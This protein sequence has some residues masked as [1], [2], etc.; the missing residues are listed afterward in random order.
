[1]RW[2]LLVQHMLAELL[3]SQPVPMVPMVLRLWSMIR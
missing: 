2:F 1:M 3:R